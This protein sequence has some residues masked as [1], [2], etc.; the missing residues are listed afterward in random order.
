MRMSRHAGLRTTQR[1]LPLDIISTICAFGVERRSSGA[2]S[3]TLDAELIQLA[4]DGD[5]SRMRDLA[6]FRGAYVVLS[7]DGTII[8]VAR[9]TRRFRH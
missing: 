4:S 9:R 2:T 3:I 7:D 8:T 5:A 6:R 1:G